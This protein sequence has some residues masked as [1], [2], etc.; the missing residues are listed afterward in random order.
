VMWTCGMAV[1]GN[2]ASVESEV[3][4][5]TTE[6]TRV[7]TGGTRHEMDGAEAAERGQASKPGELLI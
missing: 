4:S 5:T 1:A 6:D 3:T 7:A 2:L